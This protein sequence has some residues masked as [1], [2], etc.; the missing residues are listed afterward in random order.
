MATAITYNELQALYL[1][2]LDRP[3][4]ASGEAFWYGTGTASSSSVAQSI[5]S[6]AQYYSNDNAG[7]KG[8]VGASITS[9]NINGEITNLYTN[10]LGFTPSSSNA[11]VLFWA[12]VFNADVT[13]GMTAGA[14]IG[15]IADQIFNIVEGY[16]SGSPYIN[17]KTYM[18]HAIATASSFT[19]VNSSLAYNS[20][21]ALTYY[22]EKQAIITTPITTFFY[23]DKGTIDNIAPV[24]NSVISGALTFVNST[25]TVFPFDTIKATGSNNTFNVVQSTSSH[26]NAA[27][28]FPTIT[29]SGV[30][31]ANI[32]SLTGVGGTLTTPLNTSSWTGLTT[33]NVISD[34]NDYI[35]VAGTTAVKVTDIGPNTI[36]I[37]G[38]S[39]ITVNETTSAVPP[40]YG[41]VTITD[42]NHATPTTASNTITTVSL[43][44]YGASTFAGNAL[45]NL[46]LG[47]TGG[48]LTIM[49][50]AGSP[51]LT[52]TTLNLTLNALTDTTGI[53]D[54]N[55]EI[56]TLNVTT[57]AGNS[58]LGALIDS[59]LTTFTLNNTSA[60]A[61][62]VGTWNDATGTSLTIANS[63]LSAVTVSV[64]SAG[65]GAFADAKMTSLTLTGNV[66]LG[67][68]SFGV[69][70]SATGAIKG[71]TVSAGTDNAH[72]NL[73]LTGASSA[74]TDSITVGNGSD[75]IIDGSTAGTVNVTVGTGSNL[76]DLHTGGTVATSAAKY[77][78]TVT[79]GTQT[80]GSDHIDVG[81]TAAA[82][83]VNGV[84]DTPNTVITG[85]VAGDQIGIADGTAFTALAALEQTAITGEPAGNLNLVVQYVDGG[86]AVNGGPAATV[87]APH[88]ATDFTYQG[89]TYV[90][91]TLAGTAADAGGMP[92]GN[93]FIELV[94][95][96]SITAQPVHGVY[97][98]AS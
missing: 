28:T 82:A 19:Q 10:M 13:Q 64:G 27:A 81:T 18:N 65:P 50:I 23:L 30:Q 37:T 80:I 54:T 22:T 42:P 25:S 4:D 58:T 97:T 34:G 53:T 93:T 6:F 95:V 96:H 78:A 63:S 66:A 69:V 56:K 55:H 83:T 74:A 3:A 61:V 31:T 2:L 46:T 57:G 68:A 5:G 43:D 72:I 36:T 33:L 21:S 77:S 35:T 47:G 71:V 45:S 94:G 8:T 40:V 67:P 92:A 11:G 51:H 41:G 12:S 70:A 52:N 20:S 7:L 60:G 98:L 9:S 17:Q 29:V 38:G 87:L 44:N 59:G 85:A 14:A 24:G 88:A 90:L 79:I 48:G 75:Y 1:G 91:E 32:D 62:T 89:N 86:A 84:A 73:N 39:T 26:V 76:I 16:S 15:S 49:N